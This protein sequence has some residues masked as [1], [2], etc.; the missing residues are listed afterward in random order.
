MEIKK[1]IADWKE[2]L[3]SPNQNDVLV[4]LI[5]DKNAFPLEKELFT[6]ESISI[7]QNGLLN[8][9][10]KK[11]NDSMK[12]SGTPI[13]GAGHQLLIF[14]L[15]QKS[16]ACPLFVAS[17]AVKKNRFNKTYEVTISEDYYL[18]P[19]LVKT[20][21]LSQNI[22]FQEDVELALDEIGIDYQV[23]DGAW[24]ANFHPHRF[25]LV[26]E[27]ELLLDQ[28]KLSLNLK[29]L[30][31]D[32][33]V[34]TNSLELHEGLL[35]DADEDQLNVFEQV[36]TENTVIQ[37]PPGTGKSQ[38]IGNLLGKIL[39][40]QKDALL[41]AEKRVALEVIYEKLKPM[42]LHHFC[43]LYHHELKSKD[44][45]NSL[46][47]TWQFLEKRKI[48]NTIFSSNAKLQLDGLE[49]ILNRLRQ[50]ALI[51]GL[52]YRDFKAKMPELDDKK[53]DFVA[54]VPAIP[55]WEVE[56]QQLSILASDGFDIL[57]DWLKL[58]FR[59][60]PDFIATVE[61]RVKEVLGTF[62]KL[63]EKEWTLG[64]IENEI[65]KSS[66]AS[67]FFYDDLLIPTSIFTP[68]HKAQK[69]FVKLT[70]KLK[71]LKEQFQLLEREKAH[72]NKDFSLSQLQDY[73]AV[74]AS[75]NR[76][77]IRTKLQRRKLLRF[78]DLNLN[79]AKSAI[80]NL[81][82]C[83]TIER[84]IVEVK[85]SIRNLG[86]ST[87]DHELEHIHYVIRKIKQT[88]QNL[89]K[90]LLQVPE[91]NL[92][93]LKNRSTYL[94]TISSFVNRFLK[95]N[96]T[97][98]VLAILERIKK[99]LPEYA[100]NFTRLLVISPQ[101]KNVLRQIK[102]LDS[103][104]QV[105]Y[106]SHWKQFSGFFPE[107]AKINGKHLISKIS[108]IISQQKEE[109][110]DYARFIIDKIQSKFE[111]YHE[112]L[113]TS[114]R[115]LD[116]N[117][118]LLKKQL[119][120]GKSILV[121]AFGKTRSFPSVRDLMESDAAPWVKLLHPLF[122]YSPYS[123]GRSLPISVQ[124]DLVI[125]DESSQVPLPH[126]LG[127]VHRGKRI[128]VAGD[129]QQMAPQFYFQK[130]ATQSADLLHQA[131]FYWKNCMLTNHYRSEHADLIAFSNRY[132]Y[133]NKLKTY[134]TPK[135][136]QVIEVIEADGK[137]IDRKNEKEAKIVADLIA[138][139][140]NQD[141]K[142][143]GLIA[144][145]QTQLKAILNQLS[146]E[147]ANQLFDN[148]A[149]YFVQS[150]ENVQGDQ[151]NHLIISLGYAPDENG[152][153]HMRFGPLN[154]EQGHRRLNVLMS[155]AKS[156]ITFVR[157]VTSDDFTISDNDGIEI[158]RKL[159]LFLEEEHKEAPVQFDKDLFV[160]KENSK[161]NIDQPQDLFSSSVELVNFYKVMDK[162][163][164][165]VEFLV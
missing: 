5:G 21:D 94:Q 143:F 112:L 151:C 71:G 82:E 148:E 97:D 157:S 63:P 118:K 106:F 38:V 51:G 130:K 24:L 79:D 9:I 56:K 65:R 90:S 42:Q 107:L 18:N 108:G 83:K 160:N 156:K 2:E 41:V 86:V 105:I 147:H 128:V 75:T 93:Q 26:K 61:K 32:E 29:Q 54:E 73:M 23:E 43:L 121:K 120:K 66:L 114:A 98:D 4:N 69:R 138:E 48:T 67:L 45:I 133:K 49:L 158:L 117:D 17:C 115:K 34:N 149:N 28:N 74:L 111:A 35:F 16:F 55:V 152:D 127:S 31:G 159:M 101:T 129:Q 153:F 84:E 1:S 155:R 91:E 95:L 123:V 76:Y 119:R 131:S 10:V 37:G 110:K 3:L 33:S 165:N 100:L 78:T 68:D 104:E 113:Q 14:E 92:V 132:F 59:K 12:E 136:T 89:L 96:N 125:F 116:E 145:S 135:Q 102:D 70:N 50:P 163:G 126:A 36:K 6:D 81:V 57:G 109:Q 134:P 20:L 99:D 103:A 53:V 161:L 141:E 144:F 154:Q 87:D 30:L 19:F 15:N 47:S 58:K 72:W 11:H 60:D 140:L 64:A 52:S 7:P 80:K 88:D 124:F 62:Q 13:F 46:K 22:L 39:G 25:I 142:D 146:S 44:F 77:N 40:A 139:K 150:L 27:L 122:L 8:N 164:W 137:F 85:E 162:R